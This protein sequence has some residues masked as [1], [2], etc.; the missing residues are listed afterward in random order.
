MKNI[1]NFIFLPRVVF[2]NNIS[3]LHL[4]FRFISEQVNL[5]K[6]KMSREMSNTDTGYTEDTNLIFEL[7]LVFVL[8]SIFCQQT[9]VFYAVDID[10]LLMAYTTMWD[11]KIESLTAWRCDVRLVVRQDM[12]RLYTLHK[13]LHLPLSQLWKYV[14]QFDCPQHCRPLL[15]VGEQNRSDCSVFTLDCGGPGLTRPPPG[16]SVVTSSQLTHMC[17]ST[18]LAPARLSGWTVGTQ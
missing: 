13:S 1:F 11:G 4:T 16:Q 12:T 2:T 15:G 9:S 3:Y 17:G 7:E 8:Q 14:D 18:L 10:E 6:Q 5:L